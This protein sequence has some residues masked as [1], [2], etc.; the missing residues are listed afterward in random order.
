MLFLFATGMVVAQDIMP[1]EVPQ[2]VTNAFAKAHPKAT[3][4]E[5]ERSMDNYK[6]EFDI[7]RKDH[8]IWYTA[9]GTVVKKEQDISEADLPQA[10]RDAIKSKYAGYRIDDVEMTWQNDATTYRVEVEKG[11]EDLEITLDESGKILHE[12]RD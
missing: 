12:R 4:V 6:V 5:W 10:V 8:E 11:R 9:S 1:S 2:A 7:G 3:D